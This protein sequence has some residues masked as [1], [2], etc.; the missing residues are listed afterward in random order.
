M[1]TTEMPQLELHGLILCVVKLCLEDMQI[2]SYWKDSRLILG[3]DK[4]YLPRWGSSCTQQAEAG[5]GMEP[6]TR[7]FWVAFQSLGMRSTQ[8]N[9]KGMRGGIL[10]TEGGGVLTHKSTS[11]V[12]LAMLLSLSLLPHI[13]WHLSCTS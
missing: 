2:I 8:S 4:L 3:K 11:I 13:C 6:S 7:M 5:V 10:R 12:I 1:Q 9:L